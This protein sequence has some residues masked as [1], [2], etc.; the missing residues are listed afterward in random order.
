[1]VNKME[2]AIDAGKKKS[3]VV[4]QDGSVVKEEVYVET[5]ELGLT[6]IIPDCEGNTSILEAGRNHYPIV[7]ILEQ[8]KSCKIV[9]A[10]PTAMKLIAKAP[11][12]T[13]K[14]DAHKL[15]DAYNALRGFEVNNYLLPTCK[16]DVT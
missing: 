13:D 8:Y 10:H 2:M 16:T 5:T 12:K 14:N 6:S 3:Y 9:V 1:M 11:N 4:V 15:S 7:D